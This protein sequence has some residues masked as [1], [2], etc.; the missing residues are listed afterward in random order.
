LHPRDNLPQSRHIPST[1]P[2]LLLLLLLLLRL[3]QQ[4]PVRPL[5]PLLLLPLV[6]VRRCC[7]T[8]AAA[9]HLGCSCC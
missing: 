3:L 9:L 7:R 5:L 2:L 8:R 1:Q 4:L 6:A